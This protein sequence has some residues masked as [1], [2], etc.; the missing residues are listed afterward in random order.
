VSPDGRYVVFV[1]GP[2]SDFKLWLRPVASADAKLLP[3]TEGSAFP[4]WSPDSTE[5][6]FF[7]GGRLK[8][9]AVAGGP[10]VTLADARA[11]RGGSWNRDN[12]IVFDH[13]QGAGLFRI[14]STGGVPTAVT[15]LAEGEDVHRWPHFLPDGRHFFFTAVTGPC[16]PAP[17]PGVVKIGSIDPGERVVTLLQADSSAVYS[18]GYLLFSREQTLMAQPFDPDARAMT[19][20]AFALR[21]RV[22]TGGN[23]YT[24]VS[25][26]QN[27][28]LAYGPSAAP[29]ENSLF[30]FD[31]SGRI[32]GTLGESG[33]NATPALSP[34]E[35]RV[36]LALRTG[37]PGNL[38]VWLIDIGRNLR[39]R[40]TSDARDEGSPV[41]SPDGTRIVLGSG[42]PQEARP[43]KA[44]LLQASVNGTTASET[45]L[46]VADTPTRPC[47]PRQCLV[48]P[49]DWSPDGRFVLYTF[50][51]GFPATSDIWALPIVGDRQPFP[52][53]DTRFGEGLGAF[54][55]DGRWIAYVSDETG[56]PN[57][58]V[59]PFM[60][61]G[62]KQRISVNGG[63]NP[64][65][66]GDGKELFYLDADGAMTAVSVTMTAD[67]V[68][69]GLPETLF[70][71]GSLSFNQMFSV[72]KD[73]Q[74]FLVNARP[75]NSASVSP[76]TVIL[77]WT[78]TLGK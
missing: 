32:V 50:S 4:F 40:L 53:A 62:G 24:S 72:T 42:T 8:K 27:G 34:D 70:P 13:V 49:T 67:T 21:E 15:T 57:V 45:L 5:I 33:P 1:A 16:C 3:G 35:G 43:E 7:A 73:G 68:A 11:G 28:T 44:L 54:S 69:V 9:I 52:I 25:V 61:A 20:D 66:R 63:R 75:P 60:R 29:T 12:V 77:N 2:R 38:D 71:V 46:E 65:W 17:R 58:Y 78:A 56:L 59:Q 76:V 10:P 36:A 23:R 47:G 31:R 64:H 41:W 51:G 14:P 74:R 26:S 22:S 37:N 6:A 18:S 55:P 19:G 48:T 39:S 30:W